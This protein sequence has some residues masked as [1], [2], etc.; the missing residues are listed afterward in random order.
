MKK[1]NYTRY[2]NHSNSITPFWSIILK[3]IVRIIYL[4]MICTIIWAFISWINFGMNNG[5]PRTI[6]NIWDW[7]FFV[8][9][10]NI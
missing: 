8:V 1:N 10:L 4:M 6:S 3:I 7:N 5:D 9:V 2:N